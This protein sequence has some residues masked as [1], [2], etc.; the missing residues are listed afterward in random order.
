MANRLLHQPRLH[1]VEEFRDAVRDVVGDEPH[2]F[3]AVDPANARSSVEREAIVSRQVPNE[4]LVNHRTCLCRAARARIW[5]AEWVGMR[6]GCQNQCSRD[7]GGEI[8]LLRLRALLARAHS[9]E[10]NYRDYRDR[11]RAMATSLC[12]EGHM[13]WAEAMP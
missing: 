8:W 11:Y 4:L 9:D 10:T 12:F 5:R 6:G 7:G 3:D 2:A 1:A 13:A